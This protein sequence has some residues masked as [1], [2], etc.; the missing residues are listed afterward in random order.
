MF[1]SIV[2]PVYNEEK[3]LPQCLSRVRD[4]A[5]SRGLHYETWWSMTGEVLLRLQR[6]ED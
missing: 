4:F 2:I 3:A 6:K 5:A 1:L